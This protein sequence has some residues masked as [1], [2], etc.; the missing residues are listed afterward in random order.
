MPK[1]KLLTRIGDNRDEIQWNNYNVEEYIA[2][3]PNSSD[4][5]NNKLL[6]LYTDDKSISYITSFKRSNTPPPSTAN[7]VRI[8]DNPNTNNIPIYYAWLSNE[9]D[10]DIL[11]YTKADKIIIDN[12]H[13]LFN[14][15]SNCHTIDTNTFDTSNVTD[16]SSM[17]INCTSLTSLN[18]SN[19]DTS[20]VTDM[21]N[22]FNNCS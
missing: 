6:S 7:T 19:F 21:A 12:G 17:F 20:N 22:M 4:E 11:Y 10:S 9:S 1:Y 3:L 14:R 2:L 8:D 5:L 16:M 18:V 15:W 13:E